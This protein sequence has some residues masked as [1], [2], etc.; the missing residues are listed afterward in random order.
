MKKL[1]FVLL[2]LGLLGVGSAPMA[3]VPRS[4][5]RLGALSVSRAAALTQTRAFNFSLFSIV[6]ISSNGAISPSDTGNT[7]GWP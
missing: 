2:V 4:E 5:L 6:G 1:L 3:A 7:I